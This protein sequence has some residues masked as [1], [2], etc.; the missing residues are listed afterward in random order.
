[1][2]AHR[3]ESNRLYW[4]WVALVSMLL[5]MVQPVLAA[6][7]G[8]G[9]YEGRIVDEVRITGAKH[10]RESIIRRE[11]AS[12][13]GQPLDSGN[14]AED[15]SNLDALGVF[16][17]IEV[18][19]ME[20][21]EKLILVIDLKETFRYLPT[22]ALKID[23]ENGISVGGGLKATN[24]F[25]RAM[26]FSGTVLFGGATTIVLHVK[27]NWVVG[28][29]I[30]YDLKYSHRDRR[31]ELFG[32]NELSDEVFLEIAGRLGKRGRAG[33]PISF[34]SIKSDADGK[35][36]DPD[37][38][39][40]MLSVGGFIGYDSRDLIS[41]PHSGW[42]SGI[43][44]SRVWALDSGRARWLGNLD[45]R[46]YIQ[47]SGPHVAAVFSLLTLSTG[48]VGVEVA[49]WQQYSLGG[50]SSIRGWD[51]GRRYGKSQFINTLEYRYNV[52]EPRNFQFFGINAS[53]GIQLAAFGD[54]GAVWSQREEFTDSWIA[55]GGIGLRLILPY[56]GLARFDLGWGDRPSGVV[57][58]IGA[59]EKADKARL[60]V[61]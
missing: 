51:I 27:D 31:N 30:G 35:T 14:M 28:D 52:L 13:G 33:V 61:R 59:Q 45:V 53:L 42:Y 17:Q 25:G 36:L 34:Q 40:N 16:S 4:T 9:D 38:R 26:F 22:V 50:T 8:A 41:N 7:Q 2:R 1:M 56:V 43:D 24:L 29:H 19:P 15:R 55:G 57:V 60:R 44:A 23:D 20:E 39:D 10:T 11:L 49:E 58:H 6:G 21:G 48:S 12:E 5:L 54:A 18:Y 46:R 32:F 37:N 47:I 3:R